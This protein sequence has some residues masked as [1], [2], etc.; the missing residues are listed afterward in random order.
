[1]R[2]WLSLLVLLVLFPLTAHPQSSV[3]F[4]DPQ[5]TGNLLD[6]R[7]PDWSY[8]I[9]D[10]QLALSGR[11]SE[12]RQFDSPSHNNQFD[13]NLASDFSQTWE[14]EHRIIFLR[15]GISGSYYKTKF[16]REDYGHTRKNLEGILDLYSYWKQHLSQ[17]PVFFTLGGAA[18]R[19]YSED[20]FEEYDSFGDNESNNLFRNSTHSVSAGIGYGHLRN[21]VPLLKAQR[22]DERIQA[23]GRAP[24]SDQ[25]VQEIARILATEYGYRQVFDRS[26]KYLWDDVLAPM[27]DSQNPLSPFE[28]M[29]LTDALNED[30]GSRSQGLEF[31]LVYQWRE[32]IDQ[33]PD[34]TQYN[35]SHRPSFRVLWS[36]NPSLNHQ[37]RANIDVN[38]YWTRT[39]GGDVDDGA[40]IANFSHLWNV[41]D[42]VQWINSG[43]YNGNLGLSDEV[44][45]HQAV[46]GSTFR[47]FIEDQI[48]LM[49]GVEGQY[50]WKKDEAYTVQAWDFQYQLGLQYH[51][52]RVLF[53]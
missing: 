26:D 37:V 44:D 33:Y 50:R 19:M 25:Q 13:S 24:L 15:G 12:S 36:H 32:Y 11:A 1:M 47:F 39:G 46:V 40:L 53:N 35:R 14:G 2:I 9:W 51:I 18:N 41:A 49:A 34:Y 10:A 29:Y 3:G 52:D 43:R 17:G 22:L 4:D 38:Y 42:R 23:L 16:F 20:R 31:S 8:R 48:S 5:A 6:Y 45:R 28:I 21:V 27:L 30:H 7:L